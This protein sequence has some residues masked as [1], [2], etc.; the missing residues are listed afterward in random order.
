MLQCKHKVPKGHRKVKSM[1]Q[2]LEKVWRRNRRNGVFVLIT[3]S[4]TIVFPAILFVLFII[5]VLPIKSYPYALTIFILYIAVMLVGQ[6]YLDR[7]VEYKERTK[8]K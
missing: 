1:L 6:Q 7:I 5:P 3:F 4:T 8:H 2:K